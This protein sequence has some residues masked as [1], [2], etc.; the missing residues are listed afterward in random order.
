MTKWEIFDDAF[1]LTLAGALFAFGG[2]CLQAILKSR[3]KVFKC[4]GIYCER[5]VEPL[6]LEPDLELGKEKAKPEIIQA[7]SIVLDEKP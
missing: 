3:C 4:Y 5:D 1:W 6:G 7:K 2:V